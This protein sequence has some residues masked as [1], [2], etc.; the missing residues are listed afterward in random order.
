[1]SPKY[2]DIAVR[3]IKDAQAQR[4]MFDEEPIHTMKQDTLDLARPL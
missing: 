4:S 2:F 1:M 3:R